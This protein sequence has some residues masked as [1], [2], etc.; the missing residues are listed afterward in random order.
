MA[1]MIHAIQ[2]FTPRIVLAQTTQTRQIAELIAAR[3]S[4]NRGEIQNV[5][6]E[7]KDGILFFVKMGGAVKLDD[8]GTFTPSINLAGEIDLNFRPDKGIASELNAPGAF[9]GKIAN[10]ENIGKHA[11]DLKALWNATYPE[12]R[13][14]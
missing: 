8:L 4:L 11:S 6:C 10:R 1:K 7:F 12:K 2:E 3:T 14:P 13:I 5:L 9:Q